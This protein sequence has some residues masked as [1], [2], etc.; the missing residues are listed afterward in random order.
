MSVQEFLK[1]ELQQLSDQFGITFNYR[2]DF[3]SGMHIIAVSPP[4]LYDDRNY[5]EKEFHVTRRFDREFYPECILFVA[6]NDM[7]VSV[8]VP[9]FTI[10]PEVLFKSSMAQKNRW[11]F[12]DDTHLHENYA[13]AA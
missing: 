8:D 5:A 12:D 7:L 4:E 1:K 13:I 2:F 3:R 10:T 11:K 6:D 9:E